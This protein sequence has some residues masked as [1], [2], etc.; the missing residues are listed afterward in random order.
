MAFVSSNNFGST[1]EAVNTAHGVSA[2]STQVSAANSTN[3]D[4]LSDDVIYAFFSSQP[5][6]PQLTNED[7]QHLHL[8]DLEEMDLRWQ[9]AILIF[10]GGRAFSATTAT[11]GDTL[12]ESTELQGT[13]TTG[14]GK[15]Q[16]ESD[17][18]VEG[19]TNYALMAYSSSSSDSE[20]ASKSLDK[21][22]DNQIVDNYKKG[23]SYNAVLPP[24]TGNFM[25]PT[26]NLSFTGLEELT[27]KPIVIKPVVENS[28]AKASEAKPKVVRKNNG[29]PTI[30]DWVFDSDGRKMLLAKIERN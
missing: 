26:P 27:S 6:N 8:Y 16:E 29:A 25:P 28:E 21:L 12:P 23:L 1:N 7:L 3:V 18:A 10:Q 17:Q 20:N 9:I 11:R 15:A 22:I 4:N 30:E 2:A 19:P 13:K 24:Y 14:I 5:N